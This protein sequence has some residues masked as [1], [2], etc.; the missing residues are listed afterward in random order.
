MNQSSGMISDADYTDRAIRSIQFGLSGY[1]ESRLFSIKLVFIFY[2][3]PNE[4]L[5][6]SESQKTL[7]ILC[8]E[9]NDISSR[10]WV[11]RF[12]PHIHCGAFGICGL[13]T[14]EMDGV[15]FTPTKGYNS[16][17]MMRSIDAHAIRFMR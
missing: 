2:L 12:T 11:E 5:P 17:Q 15:T 13:W 1:K 16:N 7:K 3:Y 8:L 10:I 6:F 4:F 14:N 9:L